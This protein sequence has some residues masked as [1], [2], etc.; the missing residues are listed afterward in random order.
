MKKGKEKK[1]I[2]LDENDI[3]RVIKRLTQQIIEKHKKFD[4]FAVIGIRKRGDYL[5]KRIAS[6]IEKEENIK[7][8]IGYLDIT[9]YRDDLARIGPHPVVG[10]SDIPFDVNEKDVLLVDDVLYTGRTI[11]AGLDA[12][13]DYGRPKS[14]ELLVLIDRG[15]RELPIQ[16][17]YVGKYID[18]KPGDDVVVHIKEEDKEDLVFIKS[19]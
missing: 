1:Q 18:S 7:I 17:D 11:R 19:K 3:K 13:M 8:M 5:A 12:I 16:A 10:S 6:L 4:N 14:I 9:F 2:I 15:L